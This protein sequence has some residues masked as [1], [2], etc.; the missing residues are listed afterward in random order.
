MIKGQ[1]FYSGDGA[2]KMRQAEKEQGDV[3][4]IIAGDSQLRV[5]Q[6]EIAEQAGRES[7]PDGDKLA[8]KPRGGRRP[9]KARVV[10]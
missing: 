3:E 8:K 6:A 10:A 2:A 7:A 4:V 1:V 5:L 9:G